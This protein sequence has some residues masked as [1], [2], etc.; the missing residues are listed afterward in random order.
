MAQHSQQSQEFWLLL[1]SKT[2]THHSLHDSLAAWKY[3]VS[4]VKFM[5]GMATLWSSP[6][7]SWQPSLLVLHSAVAESPCGL[8]ATGQWQEH[9]AQQTQTVTQLQKLELNFQAAS[10]FK[11]L[12]L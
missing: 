9:P 1:G 6:V 2:Q 12:R 10:K 7:S 8:Q 4:S 11:P 5:Q 3:Q